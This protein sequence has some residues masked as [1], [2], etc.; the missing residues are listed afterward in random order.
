MHNDALCFD[1]HACMSI[2]LK[3]SLN[4]MH[5]SIALFDDIF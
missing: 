4:T 3:G 1:S 2:G 5:I